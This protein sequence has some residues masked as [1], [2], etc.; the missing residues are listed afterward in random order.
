MSP[1]WLIADADRFTAASRIP[2]GSTI[3]SVAPEGS[4]MRTIPLLLRMTSIRPAGSIARSSPSAS[5]TGGPPVFG[6]E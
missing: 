5:R 6:I 3:G 4:W 2:A 1:F